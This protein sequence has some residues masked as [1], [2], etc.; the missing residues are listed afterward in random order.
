M[1]KRLP[2]SNPLPGSSSLVNDRFLKMVSAV[3]SVNGK[4]QKERRLT[5][6]GSQLHCIGIKNQLQHLKRPFS[7]KSCGIY[8]R[9][10]NQSVDNSRYCRKLAK[11]KKKG[12]TERYIGLALVNV[13]KCID[14]KAIPK[15]STRP[16][17][18]TQDGRSHFKI[19]R[20]LG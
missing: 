1:R 9:P 10:C 13:Q 11:K 18:E 15:E 16:T 7:Y 19:T 2:I 20:R 17:T 6:I 3:K 14:L 4:E 8:R 12:W 5:N